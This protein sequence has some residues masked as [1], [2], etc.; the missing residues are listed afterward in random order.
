MPKFTVKNTFMLLTFLYVL[1]KRNIS[2]KSASISLKNILFKERIKAYWTI[3]IDQK[4]GTIKQEF[5][6]WFCDSKLFNAHVFDKKVYVIDL[7]CI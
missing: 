7:N 4:I 1:F 6:D 2:E 3:F 5:K